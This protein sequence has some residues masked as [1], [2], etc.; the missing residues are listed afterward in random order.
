V[1]FTAWQ[2]S[3]ASAKAN[4]CNVLGP[5]C[6]GAYPDTTSSKR[7]L[8]TVRK[9]LAFFMEDADLHENASP[10]AK[11]ALVFSWATRKY[12]HGLVSRTGRLVSRIA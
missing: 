11:V 9:G 3:A 8:D 4:G 12:L 1:P 5:C 6:V 2:V 10:A 7:L